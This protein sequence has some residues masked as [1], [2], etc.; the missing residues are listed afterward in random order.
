M[1]DAVVGALRV[2]LG[3]DTATFD[4]G[5]KQAQKQL[6]EFENF[7]IKWAKRI[8][9]AFVFKEAV[10]GIQE[11]INH[12]EKLADTSEKLGIPVEE[13]SALE[14]AAKLANVEFD[15]LT[16]SMVKL[17][18]NMDM[19]ATGA[20]TPTSQA[21][22]RL[23]VE[24]QNADGTLKSQSQ[25]LGELADRFS[26]YEDSTEKTALAV[27]LFGKKGAELI[28]ILNMGAAGIR[29]ATEEAKLFGI[30]V[31][32]ETAD[33]AKRFNDNLDRV[34][35]A[36]SGVFVQAIKASVVELD[37]L[38]SALLQ[39]ATNS[40]LTG[41][42]ITLLAG[43][44]NKVTQ[45]V[46]FSRANFQQLANLWEF[47]RGILN[48]Q[49]G[50]LTTYRQ[51]W[52]NLQTSNKAA[53]EEADKTIAQLKLQKDNLV[54]LNA[55]WAEYLRL[56]AAIIGIKLPAPRSE[57]I[58]AEKDA[59]ESFLDSQRKSLAAQQ[60]EVAAI[61]LGVGERERLRLTMQA[62]AIARNEN[63]A[64]SKAQLAAIKA[65]GD[66]AALTAQKLH[67]KQLIEE[68]LPL[69]EKHEKTLEDNRKALAA[70]GPEAQ[71]NANVMRMEAARTAE[72][73]KLTAEGTLG[74]WQ[75]TFDVLGKENKKFAVAQKA[76]AIIMATI[77]T[78]EGATKALATLGPLGPF[79]AAGIIAFGLA[80]V[81][82]IAGLQFA[83]GGSFRV[84]GGMTGI[85][86]EMVAFRA[87]PGELVD[88]RRPGQTRGGVQTINLGLPS[89][90]EFFAAHVR[91]MVNV[92]NR[93]AP[94]GYILKVATK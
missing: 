82:K 23:G 52:D 25:V 55:E 70:L 35:A 21:F 9:V 78:Y 51:L 53:R 30:V 20:I 66:E 2:V 71:N 81:A 22:K 76:I 15:V 24:V 11:T 6:D 89:P 63:I 36:L 41:L 43:A 50:D 83:Q 67:G 85:D 68:S 61:G 69:W 1:A 33:A 40:D 46:V 56:Q 48:A 74:G 90:H 49:F 91:E 31:D 77:N 5:V 3:M 62:E 57:Q 72:V 59:L 80:Q 4:S 37:F 54:P 38:G 65:L 88:V 28:P 92:L 19:A 34:S 26:I 14:H 18:K 29:A 64:L 45:E 58:K 12:I 13:L 39:V 17:A 27:E 16:G 8:A 86:S 60:A 87:T 32:K 10:K 44:L 7:L 75:N 42:G 94:D 47:F 84:G 93:A 73:W 79:A